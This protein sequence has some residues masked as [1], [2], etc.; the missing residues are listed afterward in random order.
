MWWTHHW[1]HMGLQWSYGSEKCTIHKL[2]WILMTCQPINPSHNPKLYYGAPFHKQSKAKQSWEHLPLASI[3]A[4]VIMVMQGS[5]VFVFNQ[6]QWAT[7]NQNTSAWIKKF[8]KHID[9]DVSPNLRHFSTKYIQGIVLENE[10][11][12]SWIS[13]SWMVHHQMLSEISKAL[14]ISEDE[15]L[16]PTQQ[17]IRLSSC[18]CH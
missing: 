12:I 1:L 17:I 8:V 16:Q 6:K 9:K 11:S 4:I 13:I 10:D 14:G 2:M 3:A 5:L 18:P 15:P 7:S